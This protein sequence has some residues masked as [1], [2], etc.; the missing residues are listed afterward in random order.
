MEADCAGSF[1]M[2]ERGAEARDSLF[3]CARPSR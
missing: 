2:G 1:D 3:F